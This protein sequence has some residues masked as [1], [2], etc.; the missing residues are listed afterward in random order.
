MRFLTVCQ[1]S[2]ANQWEEHSCSQQC[3]CQLKL[4][5]KPRLQIILINRVN[6]YTFC[7]CAGKYL[8]QSF[9]FPPSLGSRAGASNIL[10]H[11][12][13]RGRRGVC[14]SRM[15]LWPKG[16]NQSHEV[17]FWIN[18]S[19]SRIH[20]REFQF[21]FPSFSADF[22]LWLLNTLWRNYWDA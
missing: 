5:R 1:V 15:R 7:I 2:P 18:I 13:T 22:P 11:E 17:W 19:V 3:I 14:Q 20:I 10:R 21:T 9:F 6:S 12:T 8:R 4:F 16:G